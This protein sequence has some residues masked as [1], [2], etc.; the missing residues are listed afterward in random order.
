MVA[1]ADFLPGQLV[2]EPG[3]IQD[4]R[5]LAHLHYVPG[6]PATWA[7]VWRAVYVPARRASH[8]GLSCC[9]GSTEWNS[10]FGLQKPVGRPRRVRFGE[11]RD[12]NPKSP[13]QNPKSL[14]AVAVLSYPTPALRPRARARGRSGPRFGP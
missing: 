11:S 12:R 4:Y 1:Q 8:F 13:I 7:G 3:T 2:I 5:R 6:H 10:D 9:A 14:I